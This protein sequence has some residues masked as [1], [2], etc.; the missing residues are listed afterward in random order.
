LKK[1]LGKLPQPDKDLSPPLHYR[2]IFLLNS[3]AEVF[4]N[5]A[6]KTKFS[7][8]RVKLNQRGSVLFQ[9][10]STTH[11]LQPSFR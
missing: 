10:H 1:L 5:I 6:E 7:I 2:K 9:G 8:K 3:L 11:A 4:K